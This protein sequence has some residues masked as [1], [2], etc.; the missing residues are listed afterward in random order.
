M[1][2][3]SGCI[4][5]LF[6]WKHPEGRRTGGA[7]HKRKYAETV[8]QEVFRCGKG[9]GNSGQK[10]EYDE[11][12][13]G[14]SGEGADP[15]VVYHA[16]KSGL[17]YPHTCQSADHKSDE[18]D[19]QVQVGG[20][21]VYGLELRREK[22]MLET[23]YFRDYKHSYMI[24]PCK[25][26]QPEKSYQC[27]QLASNKIEDLLRCS[28]RHVNGM[29][30]FYYDISSRTTLESLYRDRQ[31]SYRQI[32]ELL[33]QLYQMYCRVGDYFMDE[34][35][36]VFSPAYIFYD[37]SR[38]KY[39]GLYYPDYEEE[40]PYEALMDYLLEHMD[41]EDGRLADCIYQIYERAEDSGFSLWDALQILGDEK[42]QEEQTEQVAKE[43]GEKRS[44]IFLLP[45][46]AL[47]ESGKTKQTYA[48]ADMHHAQE[49]TFTAWEEQEDKTAPVK[50][51]SLFSVFVAAF[52]ALGIAGIVYIYGSYEL[53]D[54]EVMTL[55]GCGA[56]LGVCLIAG[57]MGILKSGAKKGKRKIATEGETEKTCSDG[58][59]DFYLP[60]QE[61]DSSEH[62]RN[63]GLVSAG[64]AQ[65][66]EAVSLEHVLSREREPGLPANS[67]GR[68]DGLEEEEVCGNTVFFDS[69]KIAQH[70]LYALD[71]K[72]KKHIELTK[73]P[74][75][76]GKMAG[77]VDFVL[78]DDSVSRIHAR[79]EKTG[80]VIQLTDMNSTN[81]TYR[82]GLRMQPQET[83]EIEPGDEIR[84]GKLNYC[85]R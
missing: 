84:F 20:K 38:K 27:R 32:C 26:G 42:E 37:L 52:S 40:R 63:G 47:A 78:P 60:V 17:A 41:N 53:S 3:F 83:V 66:G 10:R 21:Y 1:C 55:L 51:K 80:D 48:Q 39:I 6:P 44:D 31:M 81:G 7:L 4:Y 68:K 28:M 13:R 56:L 25:S 54:E 77:C 50:K 30:Y 22:N 8:W 70:K 65:G 34:T 72:N 12:D 67:R 71:K 58:M 57:L 76:V 46:N 23:K 59:D 49:N 15:A 61:A 29:T 2:T 75:T 5:D 82:N 11:R 18:D 9:A 45:G 36:L 73:F 64:Q 16:W 33:E 62:M 35:R 85:Y 14:V 19:T 74:F 43:H 79:F 69:T 24:L